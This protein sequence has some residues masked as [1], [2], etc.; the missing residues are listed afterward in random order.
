MQDRVREQGAYMKTD[1]KPAV[2]NILD[3]EVDIKES[4]FSYDDDYLGSENCPHCYSMIHVVKLHGK[5]RLGKD[6]NR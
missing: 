6:A 2:K 1:K 4:L 5:L 3:T